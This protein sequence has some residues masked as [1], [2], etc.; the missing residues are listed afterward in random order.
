MYDPQIGRFH[1]ID[2]LGELIPGINP[3]HYCYNNPVVLT[4]PTGMLPGYEPN[5][6]A[7]TFVDPSGKIIKV[8]DDDDP[9]IYLV[10]DPENW[11]GESKDGLLII[12]QTPEDNTL[13]GFEGQNINSERVINHI[14]NEAERLGKQNDTWVSWIGLAHLNEFAQLMRSK[15]EQLKLLA[16]MKNLEKKR[17]MLLL[18]MLKNNELMLSD[19]QRRQKGFTDW[20]AGRI[21]TRT[22]LGLYG[23]IN[24][25]GDEAADHL[26]PES[27]LDE[28]DREFD[29]K[30]SQIIKK[31]DDM[32]KAAQNR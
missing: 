23:S 20:L 7:A 28:I 14:F 25:P 16:E 26:F 17:A 9:N 27:I 29:A 4:D 3:Y 12:G 8:T 5:Y 18:Q 2:P 6:I 24:L 19:I 30:N 21:I 32:M 11:D 22:L 10:H 1:S 15:E 31:Y 13:A